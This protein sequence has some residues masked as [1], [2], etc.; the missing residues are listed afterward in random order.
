MANGVREDV[1]LVG[2]IQIAY[3]LPIGISKSVTSISW[4]TLNGVMTA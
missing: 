2:V 1:G 3:V 4:L